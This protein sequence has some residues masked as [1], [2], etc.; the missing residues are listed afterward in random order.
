M[1]TAIVEL[2]IIDKIKDNCDANGCVCVCGYSTQ[3]VILHIYKA[4]FLCKIM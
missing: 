1:I 4:N 3:F 2:S